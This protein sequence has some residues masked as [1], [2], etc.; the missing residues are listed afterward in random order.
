[1]GTVLKQSANQVNLSSKEIDATHKK[2]LLLM[3]CLFMNSK[4]NGSEN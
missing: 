3:L 2:V 4:K 1:V